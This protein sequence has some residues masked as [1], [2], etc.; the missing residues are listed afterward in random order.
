MPSGI[1][2]ISLSLSMSCSSSTAHFCTSCTNGT[3]R[4]Y[5]SEIL[6]FSWFRLSILSNVSFVGLK[7]NL[8]LLLDMDVY[9]CSCTPICRGKN[10]EIFSI[11]L[12]WCPASKGQH[13]IP[14]TSSIWMRLFVFPILWWL[15]RNWT[16]HFWEHSIWMRLSSPFFRTYLSVLIWYTQ[17]AIYTGNVLTLQMS[18]PPQF[19][20][21]SGQY[22]FV[23]CPAVSPFE[24]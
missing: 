18:K 3:L 23:Q 11:W 14:T 4:R 9:C 12:L 10:P 17:V 8:L 2:T 19:R 1:H 7:D 22:M 5:G 20:Y 21:K 6:S 24:W 15:G 13:T 16:L